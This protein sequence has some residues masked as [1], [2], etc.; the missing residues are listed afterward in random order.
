M[1]KMW[2]NFKKVN[3]KYNAEM[4]NQ[5]C[6]K[7]LQPRFNFKIDTLQLINKHDKF[8]QGTYVLLYSVTKGVKRKY[9]QYICH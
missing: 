5:I 3:Y 7:Q 8:W 2:K 9:S 1:K 6:V 4:Q